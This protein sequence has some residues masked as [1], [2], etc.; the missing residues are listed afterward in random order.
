M[1]TVEI[2]K[3]ARALIEDRKKWTRGTYA[4]NAENVTVSPREASACK[5]CAFGAVWRVSGKHDGMTEP[6]SPY[7]FLERAAR[8]QAPRADY[9]VLTVNDRRGHAAVLAAFDAAIALA[10]QEVTA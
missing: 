4:R 3:Q 6:R 10:E 8:L 5:W 9:P 1:Q 2:L 7:V